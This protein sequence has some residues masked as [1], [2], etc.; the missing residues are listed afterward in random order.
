V[1]RILISIHESQSFCVSVDDSTGRGCLVLVDAI[2]KVTPRAPEVHSGFRCGLILVLK[3][4]L[5][6][7]EKRRGDEFLF[8]RCYCRAGRA[9]I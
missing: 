3:V 7:D 1:A 8:G 6:L 9:W 2:G 5:R 4:D